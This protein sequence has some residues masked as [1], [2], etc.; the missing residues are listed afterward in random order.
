MSDGFDVVWGEQRAGLRRFLIGLSRDIDLAE[1]LLQEVYLR[2]S[3]GFGEFRGGDLHSWL[4]TIARNAYRE[5]FRRMYTRVEVPYDGATDLPVQD[6]PGSDQDALLMDIRQAIR[7]IDPSLATALIM[8]HCGGFT[9]KQ[10]ADRLGCPVGTAKWRVSEAVD[11]LRG[12]LGAPRKEAATMKCTDLTGGLLLDYVEGK[13]PVRK[14]QAVRKHMEKCP[15]CAQR[16]RETAEV[17]RSLDQVEAEYKATC[18]IEIDD[19]GITTVYMWFSMPNND[20]AEMRSINLQQGGVEYMTIQGEEVTLELLPGEP[21]AEGMM[22]YTAKLPKSVAPGGEVRMHAVAKHPPGPKT[23]RKLEDGRWRFGPGKLTLTE[24]LLYRAAVRIPEGARL[25]D[26][27]PE[28]TEVR[29]AATTTVIWQGTCP[30]DG[31]FEFSVDYEI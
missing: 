16:L 2:A 11:R 10:I 29:N 15:A 18:A 13:L 22:S 9:Y 20:D 24:E 8:R 12:I 19:D 25:L 3:A 14:L 30:P 7:E 28:P 23:V 31:V 17:L 21:A 4:T 27:A 5:H 1:D 26:A 6:A